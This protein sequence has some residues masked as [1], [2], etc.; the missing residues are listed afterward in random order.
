MMYFSF[1]VISHL[2]AVAIPGEDT[3][4]YI[5]FAGTFS[6]SVIIVCGTSYRTMSE[7]SSLLPEIHINYHF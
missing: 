5:F 7:H 6:G 4:V 1:S 3:L 2:L